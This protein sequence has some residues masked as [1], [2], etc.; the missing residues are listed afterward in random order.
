MYILSNLYHL[1]WFLIIYKTTKINVGKIITPSLV[2]GN[3]DSV[4]IWNK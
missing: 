3:V 2:S 4:V 1:P